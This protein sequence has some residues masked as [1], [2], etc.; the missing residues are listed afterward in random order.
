M[1]KII[2]TKNVHLPTLG[3]KHTIKINDIDLRYQIT[4][5]D[6]SALRDGS[7]TLLISTITYNK[8]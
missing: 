5:I 7:Y 2:I 1:I 8:V 6:T 4:N 3:N